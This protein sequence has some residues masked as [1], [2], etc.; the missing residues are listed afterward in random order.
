[1]AAASLTNWL[2]EIAD[3]FDLAIADVRWAV[4]Y[5]SAPAAA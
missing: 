2:G 1:V 5:E 4:S 3:A